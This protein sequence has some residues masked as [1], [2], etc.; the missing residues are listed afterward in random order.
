MR[1]VK[2]K[3]TYYA[4]EK[5]IE[6]RKIACIFKAFYAIGVSPVTISKRHQ[7]VTH[8]KSLYDYL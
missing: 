6:Y 4:G 1:N 3:K 5:S 8:L 2:A 7:G